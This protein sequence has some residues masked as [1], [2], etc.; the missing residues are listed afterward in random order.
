MRTLA[1]VTAMVAVPVMFGVT[2]YVTVD[3]PCPS[4]WVEE[5]TGI[6][7]R[8]LDDSDTYRSAKSTGRGCA[9][10]ATNENGDCTYLCDPPAP[11]TI[12]RMLGIYAT[13]A[14]CP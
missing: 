6:T 11:P 10:R 7:C 1:F 13:G 9:S 12:G 3:K 8:L 4:S 14:L 2:C 5:N